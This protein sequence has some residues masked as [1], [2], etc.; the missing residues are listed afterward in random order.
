VNFQIAEDQQWMERALAQAEHS[1]GV[2]SP[3]P[4]VGCVLVKDGRLIGEGFHIYEEKDHAEIAALKA[5]TDSPRGATAYVTLEPCSHSGRTGPCC[6]ALIAAELKRVVVATG[7]PNPQVR[8]RGLE[9]MR[10][11]GIEVAIG[12]GQKK[13][14]R[15]N[16]G[17]ARWIQ[18]GRPFVTL[19]AAVSL[20]GRIA[21]ASEHRDSREPWW[22]TGPLARAE[23]QQMRHGCDAVLTGVDTVIADDSLL[24]DRSGLPRRRPLLRIV[25]DSKLRMPPNSK[26]LE[27]V[28]D[29]VLI[30]TTSKNEERKKK[31]ESSGAKIK[32]LSSPGNQV[33]LDEVFGFLGRN[34][35]LSVMT[36]AGARLNTALLGQGYVDWLRLFMA[37]FL[38]CSL[39]V[40]VF[41]GWE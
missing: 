40:P 16:E 41:F 4:A 17:F 7:D 36:E 9:K 15:L 6:D 34:Q 35:I 14:R 28:A 23:V 1:V 30:F 37:P 3:N 33:P 38:V 31:L 25:L 29:D 11:A 19:K 32:I 24:T 22:I 2:S 8:G 27:H 26:L 12:P 13:A 10:A 39:G 20:D 18:T 5:A 21:P